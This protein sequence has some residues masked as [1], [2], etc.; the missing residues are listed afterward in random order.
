MKQII[1]FVF[2]ILVLTNALYANIPEINK[3]ESIIFLNEKL[4]QQTPLIAAGAGLLAGGILLTATSLALT[5]TNIFGP[6]LGW[7]YVGIGGGATLVGIPLLSVGVVKSK[8]IENKIENTKID[9]TEKYYYDLFS[10][11]K[12]D[13]SDREKISSE[14]IPIDLPLTQKVQISFVAGNNNRIYPSQ[15]RST[16]MIRTFNKSIQVYLNFISNNGIASYYSAKDDDKETLKITSINSDKSCK[17]SIT[18]TYTTT[19]NRYTPYISNTT[20]FTNSEQSCVYYEDAAA[21]I[22]LEKLKE[23]KDSGYAIRFYGKRENT[24]INIP[25]LYIKAFLQRYNEE[26]N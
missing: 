20:G 9:V 18:S 17:I 7:S 16:F 12:D 22:T 3:Y 6:E 13:F 4:K 24:T 25:S 21:F 14:F 11:E 2:M 15:T 1:F 26:L 19:Y 5:L 10:I 23:N 8:N